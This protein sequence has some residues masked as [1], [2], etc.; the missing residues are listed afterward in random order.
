MRHCFRILLFIITLFFFNSISAQSFLNPFKD[1]QFRK[2]GDKLWMPATVQ[3]TVHTDLFSNEK[4]PDPFADD[5]EKKLQWIENEDWEYS[6]TFD[7]D[8][9]FL[10]QKN[11]DLVFEGLDTYAKVYLNDKLILTADNMFMQWE[12]D[13]KSQ[14]RTKKNQLKI[15]FESAVKKGKQDSISF[16]YI[17]PG[18]SRVFTRKAQYQYGW[19]WGPRYV[20]CGIWKPVYF[21]AWNNIIINDV[22]IEQQAVDSSFAALR[23]NLEISSEQRDSFN[24]VIIN[25]ND[26]SI[27]QTE[28]IFLAKGLNQIHVSFEIAHPQLWWPK[29]YGKQYLYELII[30]ILKN[31]KVVHADTV[32]TGIRKIELVQKADNIGKSF[33]FKVNDVPVFMK[34]ANFIPPDNF[35][36][37][38][39]KTEYE[40]LINDAVESNMNMLRVW[41]GGTYADDYFY[42]LCDEKGILVWQDFMFACAMYPG[43]SAFLENV[44]QEIICNVKKLRNHASIALWCGNN[45]IDEGWK[46]WEWQKQYKMS[47]KDSAKI[48][49]NYLSL[50]DSLIPSL[51]KTYDPVHPYWQSSP[52]IGWGRKESLLQGDSHYW[53]VWWGMEPFSIYKNKVGRFMSEY[54]FQGFPVEQTL[55]AFSTEEK[56]NLSSKYLKAH[57]KHPAGLET[58]SAY[59]KSEYKIPT[60][61]DNYIYVS[62]LLQANGMKTANDAHRLSKPY[63]MGSLYWQFN[64]CWPVISWSGRDCYGRWKAMQYIV[65]KAFQPVVVISDTSCGMIKTSIVSDEMKAVKGILKC[66]LL[67]FSG[68]KLWEKDSIVNVPANSSQ[69]FL[70]VKIK[71]IIRDT[72][73][74]NSV[75]Y[76][77]RLFSADRLV[78]QDL[79]YFYPVKNLKLKEVNIQKELIT[80][81]G[82]IFL[83][84]KSNTLA[85]NIF[86]TLDNKYIKL[87]D[88]YF[89]LLPSE[90]IEIQIPDATITNDL[91]EKINIKTVN[92]IN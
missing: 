77:A 4:I 89:D 47:E 45:E 37:R 91:L 17:L 13:C 68:N 20:T 25:N 55:N 85:K 58:I 65:K 41:G 38:V 40:N 42:K 35:L 43:D 81:K 44:K 36:P 11:I 92:Q 76:V 3:G 79:F 80:K 28:K 30:L 82:K 7:V 57:E 86:I 84:L 78:S 9:T 51:L 88:N 32:K 71:G 60:D 18:D 29:G 39:S 66:S 15:I 26:E 67:D 34:G 74:L 21:K 23:A 19:D 1:W 61:L 14:L 27:L 87:S 8:S 48:W 52:Q 72:S 49:K 83:K 16:P 5:N 73:Q 12:I 54:G 46:N 59:M 56:I 33:Y 90:S 6:C 53:G 22:Q 70:N 10:L 31:D 75:V 64:D 2:K 24:I 50:F 62:E 69:C 63:C